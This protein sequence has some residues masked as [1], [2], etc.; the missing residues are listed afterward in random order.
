MYLQYAYINEQLADQE[1]KNNSL[2]KMKKKL[3]ND[4]EALR[5]TI[6]DLEATCKK[7]EMDKLAKDHQI[8]SLQV[9]KSIYL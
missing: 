4:L 3:E 8:R 7:H 5:R 2:A 1:D 9:T 6:S